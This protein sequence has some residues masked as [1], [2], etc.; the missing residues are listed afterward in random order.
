MSNVILPVNVFALH[1]DPRFEHLREY[2]NDGEVALKHRPVTG[3]PWSAPLLHAGATEHNGDALQV[4]LGVTDRNRLLVEGY[5][6]IP[7]W[8]AGRVGTYS[9]MNGTW[10]VITR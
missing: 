2:R 3:I 7:M 4:R 10:S 8:I 1:F 5:A 9:D 6:L